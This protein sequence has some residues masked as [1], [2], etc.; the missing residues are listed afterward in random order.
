MAFRIGGLGSGMD[1]EGTISKLMQAERMSLESIN[2]KKT[3]VEWKKTDYNTIRTSIESF[4]KLTFDYKLTSNLMPKSVSSS[5]SSAVIATAN[6]DAANMTHKIHVTQLAEGV[7]K[8]SS[9]ALGSNSTKTTLKD[10]FGAGIPDSFSF[11]LKNGTDAPSDAITIDT[12]TESIF[13]LVSKINKSGVN[14]KS[15][16][17]TTLDRFFLYS[18]NS[19][20]DSGIEFLNSDDTPLAGDAL[21]FLGT[22]LKLDTSTQSGKNAQFFLDWGTANNPPDPVADAAAF[23]E[24]SNNKFT[25]SG[26]TYS[27]QSVTTSS[28]SVVV[29][30]DVDQAVEKVKGFVNEYNK[31]LGQINSELYEARYNEYQPL[32]DEERSKLTEAQADAWDVKAKSGMLRRDNTLTALIAQMRMDIAS[33]IKDLSG[34]Y[35]NLATI[36]ISTKDYTERGLLHLDEDKLRAALEADPEVLYKLFASDGKETVTKLPDESE[37]AYKK[38]YLES[39]GVAQRIYET[40]YDY[41]EQLGKKAGGLGKLYDDSELAETIRS[42]DKRIQ[43]MEDRL[44]RVEDRYWRQFTAMEKAMDK[45]N[46]QSAWLAQQLAPSS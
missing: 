24:Q 7:T 28:V 14:I 36:G 12:T 31:I 4:R 38:R 5:N 34:D 3:L 8:S 25:I 9:A 23:L 40:L 27:L 18:T 42:Y 16:Y 32:N 10:Q 43:A 37:V 29:T 44:T 17:D 39:S 15:N 6:A 2:K 13:D 21:D 11:K 35:N 41:M 26:V 19:G 45:L 30:S 22:S 20:A 1:V 33:P 46:Q